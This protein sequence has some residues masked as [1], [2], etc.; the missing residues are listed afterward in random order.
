MIL[1]VFMII[2][3]MTMLHYTDDDDDLLVEK[4]L[5]RCPGAADAVGTFHF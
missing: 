3:Y 4:V 5:Q 2:N 1:I